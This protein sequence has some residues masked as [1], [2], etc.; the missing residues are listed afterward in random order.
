[1]RSDPRLTGDSDEKK[2]RPVDPM[3]LDGDTRYLDGD[4]K[5]PRRASSGRKAS[6]PRFDDYSEESEA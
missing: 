5:M 2:V 1:M 3:E 4:R 6:V